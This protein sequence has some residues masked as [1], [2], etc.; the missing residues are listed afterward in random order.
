MKIFTIGIDAGTFDILDPL[1]ERGVVPNLGRIFR[2]GARAQMRSTI[3]PTTSPAWPSMVTGLN[4][5]KLG[6]FGLL[7]KR[8]GTQYEFIIAKNNFTHR[9]IWGLAGNE[10][11]T[12]T[13][14]GV[15]VTFPP[16]PINGT[17][18]AGMLTPGNEV[19]TYPASV[20]DELRHA[21]LLID[22]EATRGLAETAELSRLEA[23]LGLFALE[24]YPADFYMTVFRTSDMIFHTHPAAERERDEIFRTI[25]AFIGDVSQR[26]ARG[27]LLFIVS[28]HGMTRMNEVVNVNSLLAREGFLSPK[29][30]SNDAV[31]VA[32]RAIGKI[33]QSRAVQNPLFK[34]AITRRLWQ[35]LEKAEHQRTLEYGREGGRQAR[36]SESL[37]DWTR[38]KCFF[39]DLGY[40]SGIYVN[41]SGREPHGVV[42]RGEEYERLRAE[43]IA[44]LREKHHLDVFKREEVFSGPFLDRAPDL[45]LLNREE[46]T[47]LSSKFLGRPA[48][49]KQTSIVYHH[50]R[51]GIFAAFGEGIKRGASLDRIEICDFAPTVLHSLGLGIPNDVDGRAAQSIFEDS[52]E[53]K[54]RSPSIIEPPLE[55]VRSIDDMDFEESA[56]QEKLRELGYMH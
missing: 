48:R 46:S 40:G 29:Q 36:L 26:M 16:A 31:S 47:G 50:Q 39:V 15:P 2:E 14:C 33:K 56:I 8:A 35:S 55:P 12:S 23:K 30:V 20:M 7:N 43:L 6:L 18:I 34:N 49:E 24:C 13:V 9:A 32:Y 52:A 4:P 28:D 1:I 10:G 5:G 44:L 3:P 54:H 25:D 19:S 51:D 17:L 22:W 11:K 45:L 21:R 41:L 38:T 42:G 27:D 53:Q 37:V